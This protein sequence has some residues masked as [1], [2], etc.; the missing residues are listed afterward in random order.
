MENRC[1]VRSGR[2]QLDGGT[3]GPYP[4]SSEAVRVASKPTEVA[5]LMQVIRMG[6]VQQRARSPPSWIIYL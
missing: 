4:L 2:L 3:S 1:D 6:A 5:S